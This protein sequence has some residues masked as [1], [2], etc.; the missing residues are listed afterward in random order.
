[1][2]RTYFLSN[3]TIG[4]PLYS[5]QI[6]CDYPFKAQI[7]Y[8]IILIGTGISCKNVMCESNLC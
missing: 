7:F 8:A 4:R 1:M 5:H 2:S 6:S 3:E